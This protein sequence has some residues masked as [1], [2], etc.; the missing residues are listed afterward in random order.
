M[1]VMCDGMGM[2]DDATPCDFCDS[3]GEIDDY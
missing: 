3:T 1:C 2:L